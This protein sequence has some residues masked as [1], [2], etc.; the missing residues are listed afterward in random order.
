MLLDICK[1]RHSETLF[2]FNMFVSMTRLV[3]NLM[4]YLCDLFFIFI[5]IFIM[6]TRK[7]SWKQTHLFFGLLTSVLSSAATS[8]VPH[9][10]SLLCLDINVPCVVSDMY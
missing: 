3:V 10:Q 7:I 2:I 8:E 9:I 5:F 1:H 4:L 6:I